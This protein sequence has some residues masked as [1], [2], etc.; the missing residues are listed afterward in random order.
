VELA[1]LKHVE[2]SEYAKVFP[3]GVPLDFKDLVVRR[4]IF[5]MV[6]RWRQG[7]RRR[8]QICRLHHFLD[9]VELFRKT[10]SSHRLDALVR[11]ESAHEVFDEGSVLF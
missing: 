10:G 6:K 11:S 7:R 3:I 5:R 2:Q 1:V 4:H 9:H 8:F